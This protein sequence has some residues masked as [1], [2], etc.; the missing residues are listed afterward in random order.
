MVSI[1]E[2]GGAR[3]KEI[4]TYNDKILSFKTYRLDISL[5]FKLLR[6]PILGYLH[7]TFF[8]AI[9]VANIEHSLRVL[10]YLEL[11]VESICTYV[12]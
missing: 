3:L 12:R 8:G 2:N 11:H 5:S 1:Y 6:I 10:S 9:I 4:R 7:S